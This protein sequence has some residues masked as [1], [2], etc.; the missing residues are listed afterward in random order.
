M[1]ALQ[2]VATRIRHGTR[3]GIDGVMGA[4]KIVFAD[5]LA[6]RVP[7]RR[8]SIDDF[9]RPAEL[10]VDYYADAFDRAGV[11]HSGR[12]VDGTAITARRRIDTWRR[13]TPGLARRH[14]RGH[15]L[16]WSR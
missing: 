1:T 4:D 15:R 7:A 3:V 13:P 14:R 5:A 11:P 12:A 10:R 8:L 6:A 9:H 2:T 16:E